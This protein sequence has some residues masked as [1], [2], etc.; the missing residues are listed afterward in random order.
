[1]LRHI[2][3]YDATVA[4]AV[5]FFFLLPS[6]SVPVVQRPDAPERPLV[7]LMPPR[8]QVRL[9]HL[10]RQPVHV[11]HLRKLQARPRQLQ[12]LP[13]FDFQP[14]RRFSSEA[15]G[16]AYPFRP[17][18]VRVALRPAGRLHPP[19]ALPHGGHHALLA[20]Q[21]RAP[22][23]GGGDPL[24]FQLQR[25]ED[26]GLREHAKSWLIINRGLCRPSNVFSSENFGSS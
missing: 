23:Q 26:E 18:R 1:M 21:R 6:I 20:R 4:A 3:L 24:G 9:A 7:Q 15:D 25:L 16:F 13:T 2:D 17:Q 22:R 10:V 19:V 11:L 5:L 8:L 14:P 12:Y